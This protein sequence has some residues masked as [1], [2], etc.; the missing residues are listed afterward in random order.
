MFR[1]YHERDR[2]N[3]TKVTFTSQ[4]TRGLCYGISLGLSE[5]R[6][7]GQ[8]FTD[9][10]AMVSWAAVLAWTGFQWSGVTG[11]MRFAARKGRWFLGE[12]GGVGDV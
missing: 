4:L 12:W 6:N 10:R 2:P 1:V 7:K 9:G 5:M 3:T 8:Q 11:A